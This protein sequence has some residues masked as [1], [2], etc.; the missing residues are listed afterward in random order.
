[1]SREIRRV[2]LDF[3]W[4]LNE[5]WAGYRNPY[6]K[7]RKDC[8]ACAGT[9]YGPTAKRFRDEWYGYARFDPVAY[10]ATPLT[11]DHPAITKAARRNIERRET[12]FYRDLHGTTDRDELIRRE[13]HRLYRDCFAG[14][15]QNQ[16]IQADVDALIAADRLVSFTHRC[17]PGKGWQPIEP[18]PVVTADQVNAWSLVGMGHDCINQIIC[19]R[20]RCERE[21]VPVNCPK[22]DGNGDH[23]PT[24]AHRALYESWVAI[25]PPKGDG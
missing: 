19:L 25:E 20:A 9:G 22:C 10:G 16:L 12:D 15:W 4:P 23:W 6:F 2:P 21:G 5:V 11:V 7:H 24:R 1:M 13:A 18:A 14:R 3:D 8:P 17:D